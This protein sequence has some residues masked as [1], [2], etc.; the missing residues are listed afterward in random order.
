MGLWESFLKQLMVLYGLTFVLFSQS[1]RQAAMCW[2]SKKLNN[3]ETEN[4][5]EFS[6]TAVKEEPSKFSFSFSQDLSNYL[7]KNY[8]CSLEECAHKFLQKMWKKEKEK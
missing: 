3:R 7:C 4:C 8:L 1:F 5:F 2:F 6:Y